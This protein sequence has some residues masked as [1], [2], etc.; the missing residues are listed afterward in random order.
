[1]PASDLVNLNSKASKATLVLP[2][3][4]LALTGVFVY[5]FV[6][7][8]SSLSKALLERVDMTVLSA[9]VV[10]LDII[11]ILLM[12]FFQPAKAEG[13]AQPEKT[14]SSEKNVVISALEDDTKDKPEIEAEKIVEK[15]APAEE[16]KL[17]QEPNG[18]EGP[19]VV[20]KPEMTVEEIPAME[21]MVTYP[22][23]VGGG[24]F[25]DTYITLG[26]GSTLKL[27]QEV[28]EE[29]YLMG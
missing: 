25:A 3:L 29:I 1:M 13:K 7:T 12:F 8:D 6:S 23:Q 27:R 17:A 4:A 16:P 24:I 2:L 28:V 20:A 21:K 22:Q 26:S 10:F 15:P 18:E 5:V 9:I 19:A 11:L 14:G